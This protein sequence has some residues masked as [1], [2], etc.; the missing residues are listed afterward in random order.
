MRKNK[1]NSTPKPASGNAHE[2]QVWMT[3]LNIIVIY[4]GSG[5]L[6]LLGLNLQ[7]VIIIITYTI[8]LITAVLVWMN[9]KTRRH[10]VV[11]QKTCNKTVTEQNSARQSIYVKD[12]PDTKKQSNSKQA[13]KI[14]ANVE[15][16]HNHNPDAPV[17][18]ESTD[19]TTEMSGTNEIDIGC[20]SANADRKTAEITGISEATG[21]TVDDDMHTKTQAIET[22]NVRKI[23]QNDVDSQE[24][25]L[26]KL[27]SP[28]T[29]E[30]PNRENAWLKS[31]IWC[32]SETSLKTQNTT[33][34]DKKI[35]HSTCTEHDTD[36]MI[37]E[38]RKDASNEHA[39]KI[40]KKLN[41]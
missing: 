35:C 17:N 4:A 18:H 9:T 2:I 5:G 15:S 37:M 10:E 21:C 11:S 19:I 1:S 26:I 27:I 24:C 25:G 16:M 31:G 28:D 14:D 36:I 30:P 12:T 8:I 38:S 34:M 20:G 40:N 13:K 7:T 23:C 6:I 33:I 29:T 39:S 32:H 3:L 22:G 41:K